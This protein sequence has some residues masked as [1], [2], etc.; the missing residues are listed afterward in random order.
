MA[1][2]ERPVFTFAQ[3][4][5]ILARAEGIHESKFKAFEARLQQLQ[6]LGLPK[7]TNVGRSGRARYEGWQI[8]E[9]ALY[10]ALLDAGVTP[11]ALQARFASSPL[12]IG[13]YG[14]IVEDGHRP[15]FLALHLNALN[16]L[17]SGDPDRRDVNAVDHST[18]HGPD[19]EALLRKAETDPNVRSPALLLNLSARLESLKAA[20]SETAPQFAGAKLFAA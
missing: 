3:V 5:A 1:D 13:G 19:P 8:A 2:D 16:A 9:L 4:R 6:K 15:Q 11:R 20:I 14:A 17:R 18:W 10:L 12:Y 7:G